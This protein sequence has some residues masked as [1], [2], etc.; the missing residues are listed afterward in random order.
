MERIKLNSY[1]N[2]PFELDMKDYLI[3]DNNEKNTSYS[4][5]ANIS[6]DSNE[7]D[8]VVLVTP[9]DSGSPKDRL[10]FPQQLAIKDMLKLFII[11]MSII[12]VIILIGIGIGSYFVIKNQR[13]YYIIL[14]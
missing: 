14:L 13:K 4:K 6:Q 8:I 2:F 5:I 9:I 11:V 3:E 12:V 1:F 7:N 10:I